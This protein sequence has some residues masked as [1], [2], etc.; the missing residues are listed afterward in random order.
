MQHLTVNATALAATIDALFGSNMVPAVA[1]TY[2]VF[3]AALEAAHAGGVEAGKAQGYREGVDD[4]FAYD[5]DTQDETATTA[6]ETRMMAPLEF[7]QDAMDT[8]RASLTQGNVFRGITSCTIQHDS[9]DE[10]PD[11]Q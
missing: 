10:Q 7:Y 8:Q 2:Q 5:N 11:N 9:G 3:T 4:A 1:R 6:F